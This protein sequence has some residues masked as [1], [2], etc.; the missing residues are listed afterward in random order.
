MINSIENR[1]AMLFNK[2]SNFSKE[3]LISSTK[4]YKLSLRKRRIEEHLLLK[5]NISITNENEYKSTLN[6]VAIPKE[7][8]ESLIN[9]DTN[10][11]PQL[12]E[13]CSLI[14]QRISQYLNNVSILTFLLDQ[15]NNVLAFI[16]I[17]SLHLVISTKIINSLHSIISK[18]KTNQTLIVSSYHQYNII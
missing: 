11:I 1:Q 13:K 7:V 9:L 6:Q 5:R 8:K 3:I 12:I 16:P 17:D 15:L 18:Y 14:A 4:D 10:N 2:S